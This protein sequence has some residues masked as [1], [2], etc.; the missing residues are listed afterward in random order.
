MPDRT[1]VEFVVVECVRSEPAQQLSA[2]AWVTVWLE[3]E[4]R[5]SDVCIGHVASLRQ[6][7]IRASGVAC[8]PA[9]TARFPPQS[10]RIA[11]IATSRRLSTTT[12]VGCWMRRAVSNGTG[13]T[14]LHHLA[15]R[16]RRLGAVYSDLNADDRARSPRN[17]HGDRVRRSAVLPGRLHTR[18]PDPDTP[19]ADGKRLSDLPARSCCHRPESPRG[20]HGRRV[21]TVIA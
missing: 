8:Q 12:F 5:D 17:H 6:H 14:G 21:R 11:A 10:V 20:R 18:R 1:N 15:L 4:C 7:A 3:P 13:L 16:T 2:C 19:R 9:Q